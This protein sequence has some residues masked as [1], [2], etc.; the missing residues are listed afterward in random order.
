MIDMGD[1]T[2]EDEF[3]TDVQRKFIGLL[4]KDKLWAE[5]NGFDIIKP[6]YFQ[7]KILKNICK[8]IHEYYKQYQDVPTKIIL[9]EKAKEYYNENHL[10]VNEYYMYTS[11]LDDI[12]FIDGGE[13]DTEFFKEKAVVFVRQQAWKYA[14]NKGTDA[15]KI[16]NY[17]EAI[18]KFREVLT[19]GAENDL[20][21]DYS[22][23]TP[24]Q[25]IGLLGETYDKSN[26]IQTGIKSWDEALG[27]GFVKDNIHLLG[28]APGFGKSKTM[29]FLTKQALTMGKRV[30]FFTLELSQAET[31]ANIESSATGFRF[32]ELLK[33][34][35]FEIYKEKHTQFINKYGN[36]LFIK[37]YKPASVNCD[38]LHNYIQKVIQYKKEKR[39]IDWKPDVIYVDYLD[40]L[41]PTQKLKGS[42]YEDIGGVVDDCKNLA[43]SFHCPVISGS[44]LGRNVW[45]IKGAEVV[46][47]DSLADSSRKA[48]LAHSITTINVNPGEK[49]VGKARLFMAKSRSGRPGTTIFIEQD[50]GKCNMYE[51]DPW[52]PTT[53]QGTTTYTI[54]TV[55][56]V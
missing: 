22:E 17:E 50:L 25:F 3:N 19:I 32:F 48:H 11:A 34:E 36:D 27:G 24:E 5:L 54:K 1:S 18:N 56:G 39:G 52:D 49:S 12:F 30:I 55:G 7:N 26:M 33:P 43:I 38:T 21:I 15:L 13:A 23:I 16:N 44:Q 31:M 47:L 42:L 45:N 4:V 6:E 53:L 51:V 8:W 2:F 9:T 37:F 40:K 20:G 46:T 35:N 29:A 14:L 10:Q 28:G 41:L